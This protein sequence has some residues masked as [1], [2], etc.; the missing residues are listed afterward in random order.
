MTKRLLK[1]DFKNIG[2]IKLSNKRRDPLKSHK[3]KMS[4]GLNRKTL[5]QT[6]KSQESGVKPVEV[7]KGLGSF[8]KG[9]DV[10]NKTV[11]IAKK[12]TSGVWRISKSQVLDIAKKYKFNVP[13]SDKPMKHLGSTGIQMI[14]YKPGVFYLYKPVKKYCKKK[15]PGTHRIGN[16]QMGMGA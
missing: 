5:R 10:S 7:A 3:Y 6:P 2:K 13:N 14:R 11:D 4:R 1:E 8:I 12:S 16:F 9:L 15:K